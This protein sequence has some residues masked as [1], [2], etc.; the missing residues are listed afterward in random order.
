MKNK[1]IITFKKN[2]N[3][4]KE[5][6]SILKNNLKKTRDNVQNKSIQFINYLKTNSNNNETLK[7]KFSDDNENKLIEDLNEYIILNPKTKILLKNYLLYF[8]RIYF[9]DENFQ[10]LKTYYKSHFDCKNETKLL[11]FPSK[12]KNF[13]NIYEPPLF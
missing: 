11:N 13:S 4:Y 7:L 12:I 5:E 10:F 1:Q 8:K 6:K 3:E 2:N 9:N